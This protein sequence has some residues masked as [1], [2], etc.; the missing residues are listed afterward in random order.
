MR[1]AMPPSAPIGRV[2]GCEGPQKQP[3][4][5]G[6]PGAG[7]ARLCGTAVRGMKS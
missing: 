1:P 5:W 6:K 2:A 7:G 4:S 3:Q